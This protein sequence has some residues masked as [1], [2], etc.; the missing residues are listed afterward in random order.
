MKI[1]SSAKSLRQSLS[2]AKSPWQG[3]KFSRVTEQKTTL[4]LQRTRQR[5]TVEF[6]Q[7]RGNRFRVNKGIQC[8]VNVACG[9]IAKNLS[10]RRR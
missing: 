7:V 5:G 10:S 4:P 6:D 3:I 2:F 8:H 1:I 9:V